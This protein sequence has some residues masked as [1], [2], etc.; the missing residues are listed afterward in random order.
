MAATFGGPH[1]PLVENVP[2]V[3]PRVQTEPDDQEG[4][5]RLSPGLSSQTEANKELPAAVWIPVVAL[6]VIAAVAFIS[7]QSDR[8]SVLNRSSRSEIAG[9][10]TTVPTPEEKH[11]LSDKSQKDAPQKNASQTITVHP[12]IAG[13]I[14]RIVETKPEPKASVNQEPQVDEQVSFPCFVAVSGRG[15]VLKD[16]EGNCIYY[17]SCKTDP[18]GKALIESGLSFEYREITLPSSQYE[19]IIGYF[20]DKS[21][22][23]WPQLNDVNS[24]MW[25]EFVRLNQVAKETNHP[26]YKDPQKGWILAERAASNLGVP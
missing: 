3:L 24:P 6:A 26:L 18:N 8:N 2:I 11:A 21:T 13:T 23:R 20:V 5:R 4:D 22:A 12:A 16:N 9:V 7:H 14:G 19:N 25:A 1:L 10:N 17:A 15:E